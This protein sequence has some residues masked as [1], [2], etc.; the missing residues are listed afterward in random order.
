MQIYELNHALHGGQSNQPL[1]DAVTVAGRRNQAQANLANRGST[2]NI[3]QTATAQ[4]KKGIIGRATDAVVR[5][6]DKGKKD[7][8]KW[9]TDY[10]G[11]TFDVDPRVFMTKKELAGSENTGQ[12]NTT[13]KTVSQAPK[14]TQPNVTTAL[15]TTQTQ[16]TM[17]TTSTGTSG[18]A[19][20]APVNYNIP[21]YQR[22]GQ[23]A[24]VTVPAPAAKSQPVNYNVPAY[25]RKAQATSAAQPATATS[26]PSTAAAATSKPAAPKLTTGQINQAL[27]TIRTRDLLSIKKTIDSTLA[28]RQKTKASTATGAMSSMASQL[29]ASPVASSTGGRTTST[30]TGLVHQAAPTVA[31]TQPTATAA[32]KATVPAAK[33]SNVSATKAGAPTDAE[34]AAFEK[35]LQQAMARQGT[36]QQ[37]GA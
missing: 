19:Q 5:T 10:L 2:T 13:T 16:P 22:K 24:P 27:A 3:T 6:T 17:A 7:F 33:T 9:Q 15:P 18:A 25:Q 1:T 36:S 23:A 20:S 29:A 12:L 4:P 21:A 31:T 30:A 26:T 28:A 32:P 35:K 34:R 37:Q 8:N 11:K 14:T